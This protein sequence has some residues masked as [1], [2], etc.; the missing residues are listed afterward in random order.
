MVHVHC[1]FFGLTGVDEHE[2]MKF[3]E[4]KLSIFENRECL[5]FTERG[6]KTRNSNGPSRAEPPRTFGFGGFLSSTN[7]QAIL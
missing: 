7:F 6:T 3:G 5:T 2:S 1:L 4:V